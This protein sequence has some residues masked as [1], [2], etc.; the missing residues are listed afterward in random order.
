MET[1]LLLVYL[2]IYLSVGAIIAELSL[3]YHDK[4]NLNVVFHR[5]AVHLFITALWPLC[6]I[7]F[8]YKFYEGAR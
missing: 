6:I 3:D 5:K 4:E 7:M 8:L 1:L 2:S